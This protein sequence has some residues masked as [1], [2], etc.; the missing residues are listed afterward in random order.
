[1]TGTP[2]ASENQLAWALTILL[3]GIGA[4]VSLAKG[5]DYEEATI[6]TSQLEHFHFLRSVCSKGVRLQSGRQRMS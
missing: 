2:R 4:I 6:L 1:M 3:L 5:F